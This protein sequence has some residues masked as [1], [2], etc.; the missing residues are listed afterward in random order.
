VQNFALIYRG[1]PSEAGTPDLPLVD[2]L[3]F[4]IRK[5]ARQYEPARNNFAKV[6]PI[7]HATF[8]EVKQIRGSRK[9]TNIKGWSETSPYE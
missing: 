6:L 1:N 9:R 5:S 2:C 8:D 3:L 7:L 4:R